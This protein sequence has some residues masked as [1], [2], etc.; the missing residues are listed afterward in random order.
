[1]Q[2]LYF[3]FLGV[4]VIGLFISA[5][6]YSRLIRAYNKYNTRAYINITAGQFVIGA[7]N[8]LNLPQHKI[9][10]S[11]KPL[12]DAYSINKKV[13]IISRQHFDSKTVS[14]IAVVA[15]E[16][17]HVMQH[18]S[19]SNLFAVSYLFQKLSRVADFLLFP[20]LIVGGGLI[21]FSQEYLSLGNSIFFL[22][23]GLYISTLILKFITIPLEINASK[24]ALQLL[25]KERI[26]DADELKGAKKVLKAAA[27]TYVGSIFYTLLRFLRGISRS[28]K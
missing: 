5:T 10:I 28:F 4:L 1:M 7:F 6:S 18:K 25:K 11:E 9:A 22:G 13:V 3:I 27:M 21:L 20:S 8:L 26:L 23:I 2:N 15:H 19:G 24:R 16:I 14:A 17:G 12:S